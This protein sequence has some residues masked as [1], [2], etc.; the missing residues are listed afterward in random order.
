MA[1]KRQGWQLWF[2][3][4]KSLLCKQ[5]PSYLRVSLAGLQSR[6]L[7]TLCTDITKAVATV[8]APFR[9]VMAFMSLRWFSTR[10]EVWFPLL[11][12]CA[13][14]PPWQSHLSPSLQACVWPPQ[15]VPARQAQA[16]VDCTLL[17]CDES[18]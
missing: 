12:F 13:T 2:H 5:S 9:R 17:I 18:D 16:R 14:P 15:T 8:A 10:L 11:G 4:D 3:T 7:Q 6:C 1:G